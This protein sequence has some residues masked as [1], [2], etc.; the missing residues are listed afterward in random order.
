MIQPKK[1]PNRTQDRRTCIL[2]LHN[3]WDISN[4]PG[5]WKDCPRFIRARTVTLDI[6]SGGKYKN[7][8][9]F[10]IWTESHIRS[11]KAVFGVPNQE[12]AA[13]KRNSLV[14]PTK[15][16]FAPPRSPRLQ[17]IGSL[18]RYSR[19]KDPGLSIANPR[20]MYL[21]MDTMT[22]AL[23]L[24]KLSRVMLEVR[25]DRRMFRFNPVLF[26]WPAG[27]LQER[28]RAAP[29]RPQACRRGRAL[30]LRPGGRLVLGPTVHCVAVAIGLAHSLQGQTICHYHSC[31][32]AHRLRLLTPVD[33]PALMLGFG[34]GIR[35]L[36]G[37]GAGEEGQAERKCECEEL[38]LS[39][40]C[41]GDGTMRRLR[42]TPP[43][44]W[45]ESRPEVGRSRS[46]SGT[47]MLRGSPLLH[48]IPSP[49][50]GPACT[51]QG[52]YP[53]V[54]RDALRSYSCSCVLRV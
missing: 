35:L 36:L 23:S 33:M 46:L 39:P 29:A 53:P 8:C 43:V 54:N 30:H 21:I 28:P 7:F 14:A 1:L 51:L 12:I 34:L 41:I 47:A 19:D 45:R 42:G 15:Q 17:I 18:R 10:R 11:S 25:M 50:P 3:K 22:E 5:S 24:F 20:S 38:L 27:F 48:L 40:E 26:S 44:M 31:H 4:V 6:H 2:V 52:M 37:V 9:V 16:V 13:L 32:R 49:R